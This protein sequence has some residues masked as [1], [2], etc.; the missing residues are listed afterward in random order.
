M[1]QSKP[2]K[3]A[4]VLQSIHKCKTQTNQRAVLVACV[5]AVAMQRQQIP[6]EVAV[7]TKTKIQ[8]AAVGDQ[9]LKV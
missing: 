9:K 1:T 2:I 5:L 4:V 7:L 3:T 8:K 6:N